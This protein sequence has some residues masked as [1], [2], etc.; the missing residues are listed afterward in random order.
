MLAGILLLLH[1]GVAQGQVLPGGVD[2]R[3]L[4]GLEELEEPRRPFDP[5]IPIDGP[6]LDRPVDRSDYVLGAG[7][8]LALSIFGF[9]SE[10]F[11][12]VVSPEGTLV[13]P[14]VGI[15][16]VGGL[17]INQA[18][19]EVARRVRRSYRDVEV[20]LTLASVR[21]FKVF[22]VGDVLEPGVREASAVTRVSEIIP[23]ANA[24]GI[25]HRNIVL[26]RADGTTLPVDLA[27]FLQVGDLAH[28][29]VLR[30]GD[31]LHVPTIDRIVTIDGS[32][33]FPGRYAFRPGESLAQLI[34]L[35]NGGGSFP[36][37]A[38]DTLRLLQFSHDPRG[39]ILPIPLAEVMTPAGQAR[40]LEPFDA[41]YIPRILNVGRQTTALIEGEVERPGRYPI[42]PGLTTVREL[43]TM[44]GGFTPEASLLDAE[45]RREPVQRSAAYT[46]PLENLPHELLTREDQR[47]LQVT[48]STTDRYVTVDFERLF[49]EERNHAFETPLFDGDVLRVPE[50]RNEIAVL[51]GV[52]RPG[53]VP[54][55]PGVSIDEVI[56]SVGGFSSR[57][58]RKNIVILKGR[59]ESRLSPKDVTSLDP[60][61]RII[62][63]FREP[64][65][66]ME[67]FQ[68]V[69]G[70]V[71]TIAG[72]VLT[73]VA[74]ERVF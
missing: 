48:R 7:D 17:N 18:E 53:L 2:L 56:A 5:A 22:V 46:V 37:D 15:A 27:I 28:N 3:Q 52:R 71:T 55:V 59:F 49:G 21:Q 30:E 1:P 40:T 19:A 35:A 64:R 39:T 32:V 43:V 9:R 47:I 34:H 63:P 65:T 44:A 11:P 8:R 24:D 31:I 54:Y 67:H 60:G 23:H 57:A 61:D 74:V 16:R 45:L 14:N 41:L 69:Q 20:N 26:R 51:G 13:I 62:V 12:L 58:D 68:T 73:I 33:A 42:R 50:R 25:V 10:T 36:P 38:A 72:L 4:R 70:V 6:L 66:F 29:P